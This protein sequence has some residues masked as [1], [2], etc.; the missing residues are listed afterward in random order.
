MP[1]SRITVVPRDESFVGRIHVYCSVFD[2]NG[3]NVAFL[4]K[5]QEV[6]LAPS[7]VSGVGDFLYTMKVHLKKGALTTIVITLRDELSNEIGSASQSLR[8]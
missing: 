4:H 7:Q 5:T 8:L 3:R 1:L 2:E 6:T